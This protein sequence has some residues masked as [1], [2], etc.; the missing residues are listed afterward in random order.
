[1]IRA[2][3]IVAITLRGLIDRRRFWLMVLLAGVPLLVAVVARVFGRGVGGA[4]IFDQLIVSTVLPLVALVFG[5]AALGSEL[6]DG[7]IVFLL[8][9]PIRRSR[10]TLAKGLPAS[11]LTIALVVTSTLLTGLVLGRD[12]SVEIETTLA[13]AIAV[14]V[15]GA[16][17]ALAFLALSAFTSR[18]LAAGLV[19]IL[20]WEG[21]LAGL[22][23]GTKTFSIRQATVGLATS[24]DASLAGLEPRSGVVDGPTAAIVL[25]AVIVGA[26]ALASWR[27]S[28]FQ[29]T[30]GD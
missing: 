11:A 25:G 23:E 10:I 5:T 15:G 17:Y 19:Y 14:A 3:P 12:S 9:K 28:R 20:L 21:V 13:Y 16:A 29:L 7:T 6:E 2:M 1:M 30:G 22:F 18:A 26:L 8:T 27:L 24:I 4:D